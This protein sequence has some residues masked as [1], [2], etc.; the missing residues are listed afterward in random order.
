MLVTCNHNVMVRYHDRYAEKLSER[1]VNFCPLVIVI[2]LFSV[3]DQRQGNLKELYLVVVDL[4]A[5][6]LVHLDF[7]FVTK[8]NVGLVLLMSQRLRVAC[9]AAMRLR[10]NRC[11]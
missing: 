3:E 11:N 5:L 7:P 6:V 10:F 4:V 8:Q 1:H 9:K 2:A